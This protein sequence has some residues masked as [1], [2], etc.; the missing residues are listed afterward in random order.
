FVY[1]ANVVDANYRAA[2]TPGISGRAYNVACG[3]RTTLNDL[4]RIIGRAVAK[5]IAPKY[6]EPRAGDIKESLADVSRARAE[7]G[8][9]PKVGVDEGLGRLIEHLRKSRA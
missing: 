3:E 8:Y 6:R 7:L 4:L 1:I 9:A 5:E 2:T